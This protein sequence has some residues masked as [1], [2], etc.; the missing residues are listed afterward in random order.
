MRIETAPAWADGDLSEWRGSAARRVERPSQV[1][2]G[3]GGWGG[4]RDSSFSVSARRV[5]DALVLALRVLDDAWVKG[6]DRLEILL[7]D[8][9]VRLPLDEDGGTVRGPGWEAQVA[10][11]GWQGLQLELAIALA[12]G[13][14]LSDEPLVVQLVDVDPGE[15]D[16]RLGSAPDPLL[17]GLAALGV[18][19]AL[20][21]P[22]EP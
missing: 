15:L 16:T 20:D 9:V 3:L 10:E 7:G 13:Q 8:S 17:A 5:G 12:H 14:D 22:A 19:A 21:V 6:G 1:L 4:P 18:P 2:S 11:A